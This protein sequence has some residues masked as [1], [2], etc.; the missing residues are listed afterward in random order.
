MIKNYLLVTF[1]SMM[2][3]KLYLF[4]NILGMA[5][6]VACCIVA[7]LNQQYNDAFNAH[8]VNAS[9][10]YRVNSEREFNGNVTRYAIASMAL[11]NVVRDN[12]PEAEAVVRYMNTG[13]NVRV[14]TDIF[15]VATGFVDTEFFDVFSFDFISG[16][17]E[18]SNRSKIFISE[19]LAEKLFGEAEAVGQVI[20]HINPNEDLIE[21]EVG[22]VFR[23]QPQNSSFVNEAFI[24]FDHYFRSVITTHDEQSWR[25]FNTLFL[26]INEAS[27]VSVIENQLQAY[28][29]E[30]NNAREDF[31]VRKFYLVPFAGM[32]QKDQKNNMYAV[33]TQAA[34]PTAAVAVPGIMAFLILLIACFNLTNTSIAVSSRRLKEIGIRKVMGS[35]R[36]Q[37]IAQFIGENLLVCFLAL[38][39]GLLIS[40]FLTPAYNQLWEFVKLETNYFRDLQFFAFLVGVLI[41]TGLVA[42]SY[43]ALYISKFEP[44]SIL[45]GTLK[46]GGTNGFTRFLLTVQFTISLLSIIISIAFTQNARYQQNFD[47]GFDQNRIITAWL[48]SQSDVE[49]Y[50]HALSANPEIF[51][52]SSTEHHVFSN[53]YNDPVKHN[54][55]EIEVDILNVS[56]D[57]LDI[58][59]IKLLA[60]RNFNKDSENDR[61]E[62]A[63]ITESLANKFG[64]NDAL[65]KEIIWM[66]TVKLYVVG[67]IN[68]VYT[69]GLWEEMEPMILRYAKPEKHNLVLVN[70]EPANLKEVNA[71]M[72][73]EWKKLFPNRVYNGWFMDQNLAQA[74]IINNNIVKMFLFLGLVAMMLSA[75]GL[76]TLVSLNIIRKM[77][78]IGVRKV[79]GASVSNIARKVNTEFFVILAIAALLGSAAGYFLV[80]ALMDQIWD[81]YQPATVIT[82]IIAVILMFVISALTVGMKIYRAASMN[83][84]NTLR[85]E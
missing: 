78:E 56:E 80:D 7:Y 10:I 42:G 57:Y 81:Y 47:L 32:A 70:A 3:N 12:I 33:W 37:L 63:I 20:T 21:L 1:R 64:W 52:I 46:F 79:L 82:F 25:T 19:Q 35:Q 48:S 13:M 62:A 4:I 11:G 38:L 16:T 24:H 29:P 54:G 14:G 65:G 72:E 43:P 39:L 61:Q 67:M 8:H 2:K 50:K 51:S 53:R 71:Y 9:S 74:T 85:D 59:N 77:K 73:S 41:F 60:G 26:K 44:V 6:A 30:Q 75:T 83:P 69:N 17:S 55:S 15:N 76:F 22:G 40:E 5:I 84:V 68:D 58:M 34:M 23:N 36:K 28:I 49:T 18:L 66:D 45:K 27:R 31:K